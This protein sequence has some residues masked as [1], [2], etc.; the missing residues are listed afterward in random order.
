MEE[1]RLLPDSKSAPLL[2]V[3][4]PW[5]RFRSELEVLVDVEVGVDPITL[6]R[7]L[8]WVKDPDC[9]LKASRD[10]AR[11]EIDRIVAHYVDAFAQT[12]DRAKTL[13]LSRLYLFAGLGSLFVMTERDYQPANELWTA[14]DP[15]QLLSSSRTPAG[16]LLKVAIKIQEL[17]RD[18]VDVA[19][20]VARPSA[21]AADEEK[22]EEEEEEEED[23]DEEDEEEDEEEEEEDKD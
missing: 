11:D 23:E 10:A 1:Y 16:R 15:V 4:T 9:T 8:N 22:T 7:V 2:V 20:P 13:A 5:A 3:G 19:R 18:Y 17:A 6:V 21:Y 14:E 12:K